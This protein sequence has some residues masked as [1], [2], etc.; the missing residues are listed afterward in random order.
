VLRGC[1]WRLAL[2]IG[3]LSVLI[4]AEAAAL[5]LL[6]TSNAWRKRIPGKPAWVGI[7]VGVDL[8]LDA[9]PSRCCLASCKGVHGRA[10]CRWSGFGHHSLPA[11]TAVQDHNSR[12]HPPPG[13]GGQHDGGC[14]RSEAG[15]T[16]LS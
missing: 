5:L 6:F 13:G 3:L 11:S 8:K 15:T 16:H 9:R 7:P 1:R 14:E 12:L 10:V 4:L 2:Y